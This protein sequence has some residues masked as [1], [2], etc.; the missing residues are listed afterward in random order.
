MALLSYMYFTILPWIY[1]DHCLTS[2]VIMEAKTKSCQKK[3]PYLKLDDEMRAN[4][5]GYALD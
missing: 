1:L 4:V 3:G 5:F 2:A